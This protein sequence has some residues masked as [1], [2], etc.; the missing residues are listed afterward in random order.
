VCSGS[1]SCVFRSG[2]FG[3]RPV[4]SVVFVCICVMCCV[5]LLCCGFLSC[6]LLY[7][8]K[9]ISSVFEKILVSESVP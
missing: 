3:H 1:G 8:M 5:A 9:R 6:F 4:C 2:L 7:E